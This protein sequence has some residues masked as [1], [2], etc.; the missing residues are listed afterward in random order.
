MAGAVQVREDA[1]NVFTDGSSLSGPRLGGIGI[2]LVT[3]DDDGN[4]VCEDEFLPGY[5]GATSQQMELTA[6]IKGIQTALRHPR[7]AT[8]KRIC[9]FTDSQYVTRNINNA[10][11]VWPTQQWRTTLGTPVL[12]AKQWK[13]LI[14]EMKNAGCRVE[15][16]W[17]KGHSR[18]NPHNR[19]A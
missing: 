11:F 17:A 19:T 8:L 7:L 9:V 14:K 18:R 1:V 4:E 15:I 12:N 3:I 5:R 16:R 2:R 10:K 6:C 13:D